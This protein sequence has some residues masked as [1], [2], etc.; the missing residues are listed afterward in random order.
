MSKPCDEKKF[1]D[2]LPCLAPGA[3]LCL[4]AACWNKDRARPVSIKAMA[5]CP[6][7]KQVRQYWRA[8]GYGKE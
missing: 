7:I 8:K 3:G 4:G 6:W 5:E 2:R 1:W